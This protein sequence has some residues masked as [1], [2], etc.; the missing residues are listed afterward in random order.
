LD[1]LIHEVLHLAKPDLTEEEVIRVSNILAK[2]VWR[3]GYR[4]ILKP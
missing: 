3:C 4:R 1:T 2:Q